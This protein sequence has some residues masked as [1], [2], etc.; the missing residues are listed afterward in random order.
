MKVDRPM[1]SPSDAMREVLA[2][3]EAENW[4]AAVALHTPEYVAAEVEQLLEMVHRRRRLPTVEGLRRSDPEMPLAVAEYEVDRA[5]RAPPPNPY[6][7]DLYGIESEADLAELTPSEIFARYLH[8]RDYRWRWREYL[9]SLMKRH[10]R[11][12]EALRA[13]RARGGSPWRTDVLGHVIDGRRAYVVYGSRD[14]PIE[15]YA[16]D[17]APGVAVMRLGDGGW[18]LSSD[19]VPGY[20]TAFGPVRVEDGKGGW[21]SLT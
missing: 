12:V 10:P 1:P 18:R 11:H 7:G 20:A 9:D 19:I 5:R 3:L 6:F 21:L 8:G 15:E 13:Q 16:T 17:L 14:R 4:D 2:H